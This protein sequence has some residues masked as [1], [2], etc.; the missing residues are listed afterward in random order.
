MAILLRLIYIFFI[1][2]YPFSIFFGLKLFEPRFLS[3]L[4][5]GII[6]LNILPTRSL[7]FS[8][9]H[10]YSLI[11]L[12]TILLVLT[13]IYNQPFFIKLYPVFVN[14]IFFG[15]FAITL[16]YPPSIIEIIA[17]IQDKDLPSEAIEYTK[18]V[19][20]I[21]CIFF[22]INC[23]ISLYTTFYCSL[24]IWTFYNGFISYLLIGTLFACEYLFRVL[25]IRKRK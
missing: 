2:L 14:L 1:I 17:R 10:R 22:I 3:I 16:F 20:I 12:A 7:V 11:A 4:F 13:Q 19:T 8:Q 6:L 18:K 5:L 21:W 25:V 9:W 15:F 24:E 23:L